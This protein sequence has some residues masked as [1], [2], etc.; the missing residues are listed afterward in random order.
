MRQ[1]LWTV[2]LGSPRGPPG[3]CLPTPQESGCPGS[4]LGWGHEVCS[5]V[6]KLGSAPGSR[7]SA[8]LPVEHFSL[9][10]LSISPRD[11]PRALGGTTVSS[12]LLWTGG[13]GTPVVIITPKGAIFTPLSALLSLQP[14]EL[15][16][17]LR[18][19][20]HRPWHARVLGLP[21]PHSDIVG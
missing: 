1:Q 15:T 2:T 18:C 20:D 5:E 10:E 3:S 17:S 6:T 14:L 9:I 21:L 12:G 11:A 13:L 4:E 19:F 8:S 7:L 16:P